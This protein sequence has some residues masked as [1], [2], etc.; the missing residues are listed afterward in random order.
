MSIAAGATGLAY[1]FP[2]LLR[3]PWP[4]DILWVE[5]VRLAAI[6]CGIFLLRGREWARWLAL[7]WMAYHVV[8]SA[9]HEAPGLVLHSL[10]L[11]AIGWVLL[12]P[13]ATRY[14]RGHP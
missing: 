11:A 6:V 1:H 10:F 5:L 13:A 7:A 4:R 12:R 8:L 2:E 14:F 3:Q 9:F